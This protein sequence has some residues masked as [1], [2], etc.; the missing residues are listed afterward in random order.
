[1]TR[2]YGET[3]YNIENKEFEH[4]AH[5][6]FT[7]YPGDNNHMTVCRDG[8]I[9]TVFVEE[10]GEYVVAL[11]KQKILAIDG[12]SGL[13]EFLDNELARDSFSCWA[14]RT[15]KHCFFTCKEAKHK[16]D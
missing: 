6:S 11:R 12:A 13:F 2:S 8:V 16:E 7:I 1:M 14:W 5:W 3:R 15:L 9:K 10:S 4:V